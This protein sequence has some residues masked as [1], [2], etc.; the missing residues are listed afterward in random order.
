MV[1]HHSHQ[2]L[3]KATARIA[4]PV[5]RH[6][7]A[8][9]RCSLPPLRSSLCQKALRPSLNSH[10]R[11]VR[12]CSRHILQQEQGQSASQQL[13]WWPLPTEQLAVGRLHRERTAAWQGPS[14]ARTLAAQW[15]LLCCSSW[16]GRAMRWTMVWGS[17]RQWGEVECTLCSIASVTC[18]RADVRLTLTCVSIRH[19]A[20]TAGMLSVSA[21]SP[22]YLSIGLAAVRT[23]VSSPCRCHGLHQTAFVT[24]PQ[25]TRMPS[26]R[27]QTCWWRTGT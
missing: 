13:R 26:G 24:V 20:G 19:A 14:S 1:S 6:Q 25:L 21:V 3:A 18:S 9:S 12:S 4:L 15:L 17:N 8:Y 7:A 27:W 5:L 23:A 11:R 22:A 10:S 16:W 2:H